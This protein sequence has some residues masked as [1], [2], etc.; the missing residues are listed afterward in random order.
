MSDCP[1]CDARLEP[2][3]GC[4]RCGWKPTEE[5]K[6]VVTKLLPLHQPFPERAW[7]RSTPEERCPEIDPQTGLRCG[8]LVREHIEEAKEAMRKIEARNAAL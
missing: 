2:T 7:I 1:E 8:K 5:P 6:P 4:R 3:G